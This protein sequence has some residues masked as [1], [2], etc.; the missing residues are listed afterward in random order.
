M[1]GLASVVKNP[2]NSW[3]G[4]R[5]GPDRIVLAGSSHELSAPQTTTNFRLG[6]SAEALLAKTNEPDRNAN[7]L[8][9]FDA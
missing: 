8:L 6:C 1:M 5:S 7:I 4:Q 9:S 2:N 3:L